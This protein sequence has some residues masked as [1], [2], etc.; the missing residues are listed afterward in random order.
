MD[1]FKSIKLALSWVCDSYFKVSCF[2]L[3]VWVL[4]QMQVEC[5]DFVLFIF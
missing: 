2:L 5:L 3:T 1:V 4:S